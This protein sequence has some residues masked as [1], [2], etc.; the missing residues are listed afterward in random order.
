MKFLGGFIEQACRPSG[1]T[2]FLTADI[3]IGFDKITEVQFQLLQMYP[4][5][6]SFGNARNVRNDNSNRFGAL[7][8]AVSWC[9]YGRRRAQSHP[10]MRKVTLA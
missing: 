2:A 8:S 4:I 5:L 7:Y 6:E 9:C 10:S 1:I 3:I